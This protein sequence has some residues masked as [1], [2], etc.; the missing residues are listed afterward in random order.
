MFMCILATSQPQNGNLLTVTTH[1]GHDYRKVVSVSVCYRTSCYI[2]VPCLYVENKVPLGFLWHFQGMHSVAFVEN[3]LFKSS[4]KTLPSSLL[5]KL[6]MDKRDSNGFFSRRLVCR[7]SD[8][9]YN[10]T[11]STDS[12]STGHSKLWTTLLSLQTCNMQL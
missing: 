4:G 11:N 5:D 10:S 12:T 9:S 2:H 3:T 1:W 7:P 8:R 6:S